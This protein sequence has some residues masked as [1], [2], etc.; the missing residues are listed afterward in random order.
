MYKEVSLLI[1]QQIQL[2]TGN[3]DSIPGKDVDIVGLVTDD[4]LLIQLF[5]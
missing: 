5:I 1:L 4:N 3:K 2:T